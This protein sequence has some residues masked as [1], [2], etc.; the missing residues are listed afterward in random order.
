[1][2][3]TT[4]KLLIEDLKKDEW[5]ELN[6]RFTYFKKINDGKGEKYYLNCDFLDSDLL[7]SPTNKIPVF[8]V[9]FEDEFGKRIIIK[10]ANWHF[11]KDY[12]MLDGFDRIKFEEGSSFFECK[13]KIFKPATL[14]DVYEMFENIWVVLGSNYKYI[15]A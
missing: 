7:D 8:H 13:P 6:P 11:E 9:T 5:H 2:N 1:M 15:K 3:S 4:E 12:E 10:A 14:K